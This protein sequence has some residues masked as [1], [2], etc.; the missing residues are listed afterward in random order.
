M[1]LNLRKFAKGQRCQLRLIGICNFDETTTVLH[2]VRRGGVAG[3]GQKPPDI[4]GIHVCSQCHAACHGTLGP[5]DEASDTDV[6][7]GLC[8]TLAVVSKE[9]EL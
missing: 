9:L 6:L 8:R 1:A 4:I 7:E 3:G 2:H 5:M